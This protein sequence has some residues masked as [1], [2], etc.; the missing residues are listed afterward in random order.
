MATVAS[1][2]DILEEKIWQDEDTF[3][4]GFAAIV[5][6]TVE[7]SSAHKPAAWLSLDRVT[8][9]LGFMSLFIVCP[10]E[11][12]QQRKKSNLIIGSFS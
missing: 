5:K 8:A 2:L 12:P 3:T 1:N 4:S 11:F 7:P 9:A 6:S 10:D